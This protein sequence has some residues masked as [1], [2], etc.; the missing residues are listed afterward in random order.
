MSEFLSDNKIAWD[1]IAP[2]HSKGLE[3]KRKQILEDKNFIPISNVITEY[4]GKV[5][6][7]GKSCLH[8]CCN[9]GFETIGLKRMGASECVGVDFCA[10]NVDYANE[11]AKRLALDTD[12]SF[13]ECNV[14]D[15]KL[16]KLLNKKFDVIYL[17][18][19]SLCWVQD[20]NALYNNIYNLLNEGGKVFIYDLHP[21]CNVINDNKQMDKDPLLVV[22]NYFT[23]EP[24][25]RHSSLDYISRTSKEK[26][27][28]HLFY[29]TFSDIL[30]NALNCN[31]KLA[32][33]DESEIDEANGFSRITSLN[34][35]F[36]LSFCVVF[37][38]N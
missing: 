23:V 36:P 32:Y 10:Y 34:V 8:L 1:S 38:K 33:F 9:N 30:Q 29:H 14:T 4:L 18:T 37:L 25:T 7:E 26:Q 21:M 35:H 28:Y 19:G 15:K 24:S 27:T 12:V 3:A 20:L 2:I 17:S 5:C 31:L 16:T 6:L 11:L 22:N 13:L